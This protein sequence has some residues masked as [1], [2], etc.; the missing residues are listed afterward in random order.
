MTATV[1]SPLSVN[2]IS[3]PVPTPDGI[4]MFMVCQRQDPPQRQPPTKEQVT[5]QLW[6]ERMDLQQQR[7]LRDLRAAA[8]IDLRV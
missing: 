2:Q 5:N 7:Y 8:F 6:S 1:V 3:Q 4:Q